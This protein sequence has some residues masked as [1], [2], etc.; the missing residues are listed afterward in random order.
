[1]DDWRQRVRNIAND[2]R[3]GTC[4]YWDVSCRSWLNP[5]AMAVESSAS[6]EYMQSAIDRL[7]K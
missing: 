4:A 7:L 2:K 6:P 5:E 1:M 3:C